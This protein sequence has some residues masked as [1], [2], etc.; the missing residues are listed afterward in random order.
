MCTPSRD[1]ACGAAALYQIAVTAGHHLPSVRASY[2]V[3]AV[4][5]LLRGGQ[6][7]RKTWIEFVQ[8]YSPVIIPETL[9]KQIYDEVRSAHFHGGS[10]P[11]GEYLPITV[12][13][14][15]MPKTMNRSTIPHYLQDI[16]RSV[17]IRYLLI[18]QSLH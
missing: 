7:T 11:G 5:A 9:L 10:F 8:R 1:E 12:Q 17:L 16:V 13:M 18:G 3:A 4:D 14:P 2:Q 6:H 15:T